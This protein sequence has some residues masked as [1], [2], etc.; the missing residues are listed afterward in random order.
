MNIT[1]MITCIGGGLSAQFIQ[2]IKASSRHNLRIVGVD[3]NDTPAARHFCDTFHRVPSGDAP[4][5]FD[6]IK[7]IC[8]QESVDLIFPCADEEALTLAAHKAELLIT[9]TTVACN[10]LD[11]LQIFTNKLTTY[12]KLAQLG[13]E[14]P[15]WKEATGQESTLSAVREIMDITGE[16]VVKLPTARGGRGTLVI[17]NSLTETIS[18]EGSRELHMNLQTF[19]EKHLSQLPSEPI[20][21]M[22]RLV[23]PVHDLDI[24]SW[25][26][27][28]H[29]LIPRKRLNSALP[30]EGHILIENTPMAEI[31]RKVAQ[32]LKTSWIFDIDFMTTKDGKPAVLE[33]NPRASGSL[34]VAI[35]AGMPLFDDMLSLYGDEPIAPTHQ[36]YNQIIFPYTALAKR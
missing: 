28:C 7:S 4:E 6:K 33:I 17:S 36:S 24:L 10:D 23:E 8:A 30:N 26:G 16:A 14:L 25:Q 12:K 13:I 32:E 34:S 15:I 5:Y 29:Y 22:E 1:V 2:S 21:I 19:M 27:Q 11:L 3:T 31:G 18:F 20:M 35:A 9:G